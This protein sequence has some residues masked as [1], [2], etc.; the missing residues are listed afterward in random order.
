MF[1]NFEITRLESLADYI[2]ICNLAKDRALW[3]RIT[4]AVLDTV[5]AKYLTL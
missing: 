5:K 4:K 3:R 2:D 1:N